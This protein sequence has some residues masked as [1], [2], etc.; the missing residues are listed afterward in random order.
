MMTEWDIVI[1]CQQN[2]REAQRALYDGYATRL[3]AL[4]MRYMGNQ[5]DAEDVVQDALLKAYHGIT[6][7]TWM[8]NG[9]LRAWLERITIN[10]A[11][12]VLRERAR[13]SDGMWVDWMADDTEEPDA[14]DV[15]QIDAETIGEMI[16]SLPTG[17]RTVFN[18]YCIDGFSHREIANQLGI[19]EG[20]SSSQ[21]SRARALLAHKIKEYL[22]HNLAE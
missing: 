17:Y 13:H 21:L 22:K 14:T 7:F 3:M 6:R 1:G 11:V 8:G 10:A 18:M 20:T 15:E 16:A 19:N 4:A 12:N 5:E 9:S 2:R